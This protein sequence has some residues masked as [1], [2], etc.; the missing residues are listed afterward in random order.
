MKHVA[1]RIRARGYKPRCRGFES[2]LGKGPFPLGESITASLRHLLVLVHLRT[3]NWLVVKNLRT[4]EQRIT[5]DAYT[6]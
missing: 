5:L 1:Q 6:E 4:M 3:L 2:L